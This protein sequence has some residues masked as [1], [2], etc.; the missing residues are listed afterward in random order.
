MQSLLFVYQIL[1]KCKK[2]KQQL[3][4]FRA[5]GL[6]KYAE[7]NTTGPRIKLYKPIPIF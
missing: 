4:P 6:R 7:S 3:P 1:A 2:K 5:G